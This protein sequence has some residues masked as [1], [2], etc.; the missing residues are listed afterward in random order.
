MQV[1]PKRD[2]VRRC[3]GNP[4]ITLADV[5]F[6]CADIC[7]AGAVKKDGE[8]ILLLTIQSLEGFAEIYPARSSDGYTFDVGREPLIT[9]TEEF[10]EYNQMG[11]LDPRVTFLEGYY[12]ITYD[13]AGQHGYRLAL[14]R[15]KD[16]KDIEKLGFISQP[17]AKAGAL[18]PDKIRGKYAR[19]ERHW[20]GGSVW[21]SYSD[22][23]E[24]WGWSDVVLTPRGGF[25][26]TSRVGAATPPIRVDHGWLFI[27][28]GVKDT[29]AGP[30]FRLG[31]AIVDEDDP[32]IVRHRTNVPILSPREEYERIGD[33]PNL[34][35]SCGAILEPNGELKLYY[36]ASDSCICVGTT[37]VEYILDACVESDKEF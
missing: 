7:N 3:K 29:S 25:W 13:A 10:K 26:D 17:D 6:R 12:Y 28:Y 27:Y 19:L 35:F 18:F 9:P 4:I 1:V 11:V 20:N 8:Y 2:I 5:P 33:I 36:G 32:S 22:D 37:R 21:V 16:F 30:L 34:V 15:T 14:A 31:A 23:L 24:Y